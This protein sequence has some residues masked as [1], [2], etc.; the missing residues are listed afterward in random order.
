MKALEE[1]GIG[2]P[3]TYAPTIT[4]LIARRYVAKE[5]K[6]LYLSEL[7]DIVNQIMTSAFSSI[8]DVNFT[9]TMEMLLDGVA[10]GSVEWKNIIRNF[11]PDLEKAVSHA[12]QALE[13]IE[14]EDEVTDT[15]CENCGRNMVIKYGPHGKFLACPGFPDCRNTKPYFEK[16]GVTCNKCGGEI[17]IKKTQKGR[18]YYGCENYP[19][20]D[21]M[22]W[23]RPS[24]QCCPKC[25]NMLLEKGNK[26]VCADT[27]C[28][29]KKEKEPV[30]MEEK[31]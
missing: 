29:F 23:Q 6:N 1:L 18:R 2:R 22:T 31:K 17:V 16:I 13:K 4:T 8:V 14:I 25:G 20:C 21:V 3:S 26:L 10:E 28:G 11:Y 7:G 15:I 12:E 27:S 9:A 5:Q 24:D 30:A 19:E